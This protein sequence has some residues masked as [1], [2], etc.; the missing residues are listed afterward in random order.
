MLVRADAGINV[1]TWL[2]PLTKKKKKKEKSALVSHRTDGGGGELTAAVF[3]HD[4]LN[5]K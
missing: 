3:S 2:S 1:N 4:V 5:A